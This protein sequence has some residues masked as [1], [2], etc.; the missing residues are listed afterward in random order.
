MSRTNDF[1]V[2]NTMPK[3]LYDELQAHHDSIYVIDV[4]DKSF[5]KHYKDNIEWQQADEMAKEAREHKKEIEFQ[6]RKKLKP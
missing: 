4:Y 2:L 5:Y 1:Y 3:S 6:I